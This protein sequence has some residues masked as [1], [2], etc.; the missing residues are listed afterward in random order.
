MVKRH[1]WELCPESEALSLPSPLKAS[2]VKV[3]II[4]LG[5]VGATLLLGLKLLGDVYKRQ[6]LPSSTLPILL[7]TPV[8]KRAASRKVVLPHPP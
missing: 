8:A 5:D 2:G 4:A 3:N 7:M 1:I 6:V